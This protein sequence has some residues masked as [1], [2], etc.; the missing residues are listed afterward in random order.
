MPFGIF[1]NR[2]NRPPVLENE[3]FDSEMTTT[4]TTTTTKRVEGGGSWA[5]GRDG[6]RG[7]CGKGGWLEVEER[8]WEGNYEI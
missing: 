8:G 6:G 1:W 3:V 4:T 5:T 7:G 2:G